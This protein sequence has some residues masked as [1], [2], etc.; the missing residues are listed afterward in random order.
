MVVVTVKPSVY[1]NPVEILLNSLVPVNVGLCVKARLDAKALV[2]V[3]P[4]VR[5]QVLLLTKTLQ[6]TVRGLVPVKPAVREKILVAIKMVLALNLPLARKVALRLRSELI[7][8]S[9]VWF[10]VE[11][12]L[13]VRKVRLNCLVKL[14][15]LLKVKI[16]LVLIPRD[17]VKTGLRVKLRELVNLSDDGQLR[18]RDH[19]T[20]TLSRRLEDP[21]PVLESPL[22]A[23]IRLDCEKLLVPTNRLDAPNIAE[24][25]NFSELIASKCGTVP[26]NSELGDRC[27]CVVYIPVNVG[28]SVKTNDGVNGLVSAFV[29][30][31][32]TDAEKASVLV[33]KFE[34][35]KPSEY[36]GVGAGVKLGPGKH[37][38]FLLT[39]ILRH[40]LT[41]QVS[42]TLRSSTIILLSGKAMNNWS[43]KFAPG[44]VVSNRNG[45]L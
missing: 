38:R 33:T 3:R 8:M 17:C 4:L 41:S 6:V 7:V 11:V 44:R 12:R 13:K 28:D 43:R 22:V 1:E 16:R 30:M 29:I 15:L 45:Y 14:N 2:R 9:L 26:I 24:G 34:K 40:P 39:S 31:N 10:I 42:E 5:R 18:D 36:V 32:A 20:D 25:E 21:R 19:M 23:V 27:G 35:L 37:N